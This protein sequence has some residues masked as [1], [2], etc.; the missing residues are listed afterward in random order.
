MEN[1]FI[2]TEKYTNRL[3]KRYGKNVIVDRQYY[4]E[5]CIY[6]IKFVGF[7]SRIIFFKEYVQY[8]KNVKRAFYSH[9]TAF[10]LS[11]KPTSELDKIE[12]KKKKDAYDLARLETSYPNITFKQ[13]DEILEKYH[14]PTQRK[15]Y[16]YC[17]KYYLSFY[18]DEAYRDQVREELIKTVYVEK[19]DRTLEDG[20]PNYILLVIKDYVDHLDRKYLSDTYEDLEVYGAYAEAD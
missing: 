13:L 9:R 5:C 10:N 3:E 1:K 8:F 12:Y 15:Y 4:E 6:T 17:C 18:E 16:E 19:L 7:F 11:I 2:D 20:S 14:R